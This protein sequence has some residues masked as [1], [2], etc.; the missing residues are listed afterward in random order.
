MYKHEN[1]DEVVESE[2]FILWLNAVRKSRP[3]EEAAEVEEV[4]YQIK[5][6]PTKA[7]RL[8]KT[9]QAFLSPGHLYNS[10]NV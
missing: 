6:K 3:M 2:G 4:P 8:N 10:C 5:P 9:K 7:K 1:M